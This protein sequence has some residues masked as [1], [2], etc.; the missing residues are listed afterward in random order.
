[1]IGK[2]SGF[3]GNFGERFNSGR[4]EDCC[5]ILMTFLFGEKFVEW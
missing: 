3:F 2:S 4:T 5:A 1:M